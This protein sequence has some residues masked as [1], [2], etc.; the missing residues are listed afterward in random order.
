MRPGLSISKISRCLNCLR[1][2]RSPAA[3]MRACV[4][5]GLWRS[6]SARIANPSRRR[7]LA[8]PTGCGSDRFIAVHRT[9]KHIVIE[10]GRRH[11]PAASEE[12]CGMGRIRDH[13][14]VDRA[15]GHDGATA[16]DHSRMRRLQNTRM[17]AELAQRTGAALRRSAAVWPAGVS[18]S[19]QGAGIRR[20]WARSPS[21]IERRSLQSCFTAESWRSKR[22]CST[23]PCSRAWETSMPMRACFA[24]EFVRGAERG[25]LTRAE[26]EKLRLG[27]ARCPGTGDPAWRIVGFGLCGCRRRARILPVGALRVPANRR[28]MPHVRECDPAH[29][30]G[31]TGAPTTV[32]HCQQ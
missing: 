10:L 18:R 25:R 32:A 29:R 27:A 12:A 31:R 19:A 8:R 17:P 9:G 14:A 3:W 30:G 2:R 23:R 28:A 5:T 22:R 11:W 21:S 24:R 6:G 13:C 1:W 7:R 4:A 26:L 20:A 15:P 16:G